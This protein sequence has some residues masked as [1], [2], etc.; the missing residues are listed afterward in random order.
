MNGVARLSRVSAAESRPNVVMILTDD[1]R[2]D[3]A[4]FTGNPAIHTPN[5]DRLANTG[6]IFRNCFGNTSICC[7]NR[8]ESE[9]HEHTS[10]HPRCGPPGRSVAY[11]GVP[12]IA[13]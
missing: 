10:F 7:V 3:A 8:I 1:Q 9:P 11:H 6:L 12:G 5:L 2:H 4:G 13:G